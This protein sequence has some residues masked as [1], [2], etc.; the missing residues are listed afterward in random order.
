MEAGTLSF[1]ADGLSTTDLLQSMKL[2][3]GARAKRFDVQRLQTANLVADLEMVGDSSH[4]VIEALID[5]VVTVRGRGSAH[6]A[7]RLFAFTFDRLQAQFTSHDFQN[8]GPVAFKVGRDG[9]R[10]RTCFCTTKQKK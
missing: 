2:S 8:S 7:N 6:Y 10:S 4:I 5:S 9:F 1:N 3:L